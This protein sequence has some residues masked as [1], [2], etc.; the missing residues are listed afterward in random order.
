MPPPYRTQYSHVD[1][2]C[3]PCSCFEQ[4]SVYAWLKFQ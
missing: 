3:N 2:S 1:H 4:G